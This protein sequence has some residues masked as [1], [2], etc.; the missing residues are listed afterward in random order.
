MAVA[1]NVV[2][3]Q[4]GWFACVLGAAHGKPWLGLAVA[5]PIVAWHVG[6]AREPRR[7]AALV[8]CIALLGALFET[9]L[10]QS[11]WVR[12]ETGV[13]IDGVAPYWMIA[14]W[15]LF[16]TTFNVSLRSLRD[17]PGLAAL[18]AL[19]GAPASYYAGARLGALEFVVAGAALAAIG[20]GW[21]LLAPL[22]LR[23]AKR[24]DG[25]APA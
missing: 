25:Y 23:A 7:E 13:L 20:I 6:R 17:R 3:S 11:G 24:F 4:A 18:L 10:L 2:L 5:A 14:L 1:L 15:A 19:V 21:A 16:A 22:M 9:L 12:F 8:A